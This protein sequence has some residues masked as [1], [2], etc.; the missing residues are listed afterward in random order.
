M[1]LGEPAGGVGAR[2]Q[3]K[4]LKGL[5]GVCKAGCRRERVSQVWLSRFTLG[6][7]LWSIF[8]WCRV[9]LGSCCRAASLSCLSRTPCAPR[10]LTLRLNP[11]LT[12]LPQ[13]ESGTS[14]YTC[15]LPFFFVFSFGSWLWS[16][17]RDRPPRR[18]GR[19]WVMAQCVSKGLKLGLSS[20]AERLAEG[21][22]VQKENEGLGDPLLQHPATPLLPKGAF[23]LSH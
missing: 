18:H 22:R 13:P 15:F 9:F 6:K 5:E 23:Y 4:G 2:G 11:E 17:P 3:C 7:L 20:A 1:G 10:V 16:A 12:P 14:E 21:Y 8:K 19:R